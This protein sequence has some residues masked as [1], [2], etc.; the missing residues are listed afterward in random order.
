[1]QIHAGGGVVQTSKIKQ[2]LNPYLRI[3]F[4]RFIMLTAEFL[5]PRTWNSI[6]LNSSLWDFQSFH[7]KK[8]MMHAFL[9]PDIKSQRME[10]WFR[11]R[12]VSSKNHES[13]TERGPVMTRKINFSML[14]WHQ[15]L[16]IH[17]KPLLHNP[18]QHLSGRRIMHS[19]FP[20][21]F[22]RAT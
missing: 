15:Q 18:P 5:L 7:M 3:S 8:I 9:K 17:P 2:N 22:E 1:M 14:L 19:A 10:K 13:R 4:S 20:R 16:S 11:A 21:A 12:A 6:F